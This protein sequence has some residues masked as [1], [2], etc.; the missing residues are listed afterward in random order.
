MSGV[1]RH[2]RQLGRVWLALPPQPVGIIQFIGGNGLAV[3]PQ[4][5]YQRL[6]RAFEA[7]GWGVL[8]WAYRL[9]LDHQQQ[10][11]QAFLD[12]ERAL[13]REPGLARLPLLRVGH[14]LGCKLL[15]LAPD[16]G[17]GCG[18]A[19]MLAF[20]NYSAGRSIPLVNQLGPSLGFT[21][22]FNP[23]PRRTMELV[24]ERYRQP[25]N[26]LVRFR[27][28]TI[29]Q[30]PRLYAQLQARSGDQS[31]IVVL[32]GKHTTPASTGLRQQILGTVEDPRGRRIKQLADQVLTLGQ[33]LAGSTRPPA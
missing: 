24:V 33:R 13:R 15:L 26:L 17:L 30:S 23:P 7:Q 16:E 28:D 4:W 5:S 31:Q 18:G 14:S 22:E 25:R 21:V 29:D 2:W 12:L 9:S 10:A 3:Q 20:N 11:D 8:T 19:A 27:D 1:P 32:P 6:L